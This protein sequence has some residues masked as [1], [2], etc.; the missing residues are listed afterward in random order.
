MTYNNIK[1]N[2][3]I[4]R[5]CFGIITNNCEPQH[6]P[7]LIR[8]GYALDNYICPRNARK[9]FQPGCCFASRTTIQK[10]QPKDI[11]R[12]D[13]THLAS[14]PLGCWASPQ[15]S[16]CAHIVKVAT[17]PKKQHHRSWS[18]VPCFALIPPRIWDPSPGQQRWVPFFKD[19]YP[20]WAFLKFQNAGPKNVF[21]DHILWLSV[22]QKDLERELA[23]PMKTIRFIDWFCSETQRLFAIFRR[24]SRIATDPWTTKEGRVLLTSQGAKLL[25]R[26]SD[27]FFVFCCQYMKFSEDRRQR[28]QTLV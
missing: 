13:A 3:D 28:V 10:P 19:L 24:A 7:G 6:C 8:G 16:S 9:W 26:T 27:F 18:R 21:A 20:F 2:S 15:R 14:C 12:C 4:A 5:D 25:S 17:V 11:I 22:R 23:K 1:G